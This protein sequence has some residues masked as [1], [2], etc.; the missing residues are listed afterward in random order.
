MLKFFKISLYFY[1]A[2]KIVQQYILNDFLCPT[3]KRAVAWIQSFPEPV[4][5]KWGKKGLARPVPIK[6]VSRDPAKMG[7]P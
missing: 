2:F 4:C 7:R 5:R 6:R 1:K 3:G